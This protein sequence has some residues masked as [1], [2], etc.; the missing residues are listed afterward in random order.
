M[1]FRYHHDTVSTIFLDT[2]NRYGQVM[3]T[4][5]CIEKNAGTIMQGDA[6]LGNKADAMKSYLEYVYPS[7][8]AGFGK[9]MEAL[10]S[11]MELYNSDCLAIEG[12][13]HAVIHE[14]RI[15]EAIDRIQDFSAEILPLGDDANQ[16]IHSVSDLVQARKVDLS[17]MENQLKTIQTELET[18]A[19]DINANESKYAERL[20]KDTIDLITKT[21]A[22]VRY[23]QS[24]SISRFNPKNLGSCKEYIALANIYNK[25]A[26]QLEVEA[27]KVVKA[28]ESN[29]EMVD[30]LQKEYEERVREAQKWKWLAGIAC[31][32]IT[33]AVSAVTCGAGAVV[34]GAITGAVTGAVSSGI[35]SY[36]DQQVGTLACAGKVSWGKV[37]NEAF[38]GAVVGGVTGAIG[39]KFDALKTS[40]TGLKAFGQNVLVA[41]TKKVTTG[42][43]SRGLQT[44]MDTLE[45]GGCIGTALKESLSSAFNTDALVKDAISGAASGVVKEGVRQ[46]DKK[47]NL[48]SKKEDDFKNHDYKESDKQVTYQGTSFGTKVLKS[49]YYGLT[50]MVGSAGGRFASAMYST[51]GDISASLDTAKE[52]MAEELI[53]ST[54]A[55]L[56]GETIN[57]VKEMKYTREL[58]K[59]QQQV[60]QEAAARNQR[61]EKYYDEW[62]KSNVDHTKNG[63]PDF[64]NS[65][66]FAGETR[67]QLSY[68]D[69]GSI[70]D[71]DYRN[72]YDKLVAE[73]IVDPNIIIRD[74]DGIYKV[75]PDNGKRTY[76]TVH[77]LDDYNVKDGTATVQ[78]VERDLH[79]DHDL[80]PDHTGSVSQINS[81]YQN[82]NLKDNIDAANKQVT[83][84]ER[85]KRGSTMRSSTATGR[86][87]YNRE[88][89]DVEEE[90][91]PED[92]DSVEYKQKR[93][94]FTFAP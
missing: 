58:E 30:Q 4:L 5:G 65:D 3:G 8:N 12:N 59:I 2:Q 42:I 76:Y 64:K 13:I 66:G 62:E 20:S 63:A 43:A 45:S 78:L 90:H 49:G 93:Y 80:I 68:G 31:A 89:T 82:H 27:D 14:D 19:E 40:S 55:T 34:A 84:N 21:V 15:I 46:T 7:I 88:L 67:I 72:A 85:L 94:T 39:G 47:F 33:V 92:I 81:A 86:S 1:G 50:E 54:V 10:E 83:D 56:T 38:K 35:N 6:W 74:K 26:D 69:D 57:H 87:T 17:L 9:A 24:Q 61:N 77:H 60:D 70:R 75:D 91:V 44:G 73:G 22:F 11:Q 29:K 37:A 36:L 71:H 41:T 25:V 18:L 23:A 51:Q 79:S 53:T 16:A 48:F 32:V 28:R 52:G